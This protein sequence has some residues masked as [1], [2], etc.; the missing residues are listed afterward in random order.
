MFFFFHVVPS[1][2]GVHLVHI[3][4]RVLSNVYTFEI[5]SGEGGVC[6]HIWKRKFDSSTGAHPA[7]VSRR[8]TRGMGSPAL[9]AALGGRL[10][11]FEKDRELLDRAG[12]ICRQGGV[13]WHR[14]I[15]KLAS[16]ECQTG[17]TAVNL[18]AGSSS[19]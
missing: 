18:A 10:P 11:N 2:S 6:F 14:Q 1:I 7:G 12:V 19:A 8:R 15:W 3:W 16:E 5:V 4:K 9:G 17:K 13:L